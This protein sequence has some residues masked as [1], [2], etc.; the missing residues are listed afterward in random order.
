MKRFAG[1]SLSCSSL[2]VCCAGVSSAFRLPIVSVLGLVAITTTTHY[3]VHHHADE[4]GMGWQCG[5]QYHVT[6]TDMVSRSVS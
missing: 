1:L 5:H 3:T 6:W 4:C 2:A